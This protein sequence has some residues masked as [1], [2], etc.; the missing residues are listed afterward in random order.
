MYPRSEVSCHCSLCFWSLHNVGCPHCMASKTCQTQGN[1]C[2]WRNT[3]YTQCS[4][5]PL[6]DAAIPVESAQS[7][8]T[9]P[10]MQTLYMHRLSA[11][12]LQRLV[13]SNTFLS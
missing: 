8:V 6:P 9:L 1:K 10:S 7:P 11:A 3:Y 13:P 4:H 5:E 2:Y 12:S